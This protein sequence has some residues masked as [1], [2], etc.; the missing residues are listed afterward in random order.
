MA[1]SVAILNMFIS[2]QESFVSAPEE[3]GGSTDQNKYLGEK[4]IPFL[5]I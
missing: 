4:D 1:L 5:K 3:E 2:M